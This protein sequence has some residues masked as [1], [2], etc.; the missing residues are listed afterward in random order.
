MMHVDVDYHHSESRGASGDVRDVSVLS[1][2]R[3]TC[4]DDGQRLHSGDETEYERL[5]RLV[6]LHY[7]DGQEFNHEG[8]GGESKPLGPSD[9]EPGAR[10]PLDRDCEPVPPELRASNDE[11]DHALYRASDSTTPES[12]VPQAHTATLVTS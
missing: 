3:Q 11:Q 7:G 2:D 12:K 9:V 1:Q 10:L 6:M 4:G 8:A 5:T